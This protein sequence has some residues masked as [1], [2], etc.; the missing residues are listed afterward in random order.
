[1]LMKLPLEATY[2]ENSLVI[3]GNIR[4]NEYICLPCIGYQFDEVMDK[5][6]L[7]I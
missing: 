4:D 2:E 1:M 5:N 6:N 3:L 7:A